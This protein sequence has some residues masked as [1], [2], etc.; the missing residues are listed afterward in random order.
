MYPECAIASW[1]AL[2]LLVDAENNYWMKGPIECRKKIKC[3][4]KLQ[5]PGKNMQLCVLWKQFLSIDWL[6]TVYFAVNFQTKDEKPLFSHPFPQ[7][8][9][10]SF[11]CLNS[12]VLRDVIQVVFWWDNRR[13]C[14]S[15]NN[16]LSFQSTLRLLHAFQAN[17]KL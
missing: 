6:F 13:H 2:I 1:D 12:H 4:C 10:L 8:L 14:R 9:V 3:L 16:N 5:T 15:A 11:L 17:F 7:L